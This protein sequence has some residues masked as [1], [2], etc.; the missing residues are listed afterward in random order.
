M[1]VRFAPESGHPLAPSRCPL[2]VKNVAF[3]HLPEVRLA[4][5]SDRNSDLPD[6]CRLGFELKNNEYIPVDT[7]SFETSMPGI[8]AIGDI[9]WYPGKLRLSCPDSTKA[10]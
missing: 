10:R 5:D 7:E 1:D 2:W 3:G 4:P 8:F 9:N 6:G